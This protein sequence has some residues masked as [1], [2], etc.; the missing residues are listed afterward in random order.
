[1]VLLHQ[2]Q[3]VSSL[4]AS[5]FSMTRA[6]DPDE[7][8]EATPVNHIFPFK[9]QHGAPNLLWATHGDSDNGT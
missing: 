7:P 2:L 4:I 8:G 1:M 9:I 3:P 6:E 5:Y